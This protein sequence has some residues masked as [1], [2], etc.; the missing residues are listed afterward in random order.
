MVN[1][2]TYTPFRGVVENHMG[3]PTRQTRQLAKSAFV[4]GKKVSGSVPDTSR[5][6]G[7]LVP[8][9]PFW[10]AQTGVGYFTRHFFK[11]LG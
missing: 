11:R 4:I 9:I 3:Q 2:F 1:H 8:E 10:R 7:F 5:H 6:L